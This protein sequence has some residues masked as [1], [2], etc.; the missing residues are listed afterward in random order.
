MPCVGR[1]PSDKNAKENEDINHPGE[2]V[3]YESSAGAG[4]LEKWEA[5]R[6]VKTGDESKA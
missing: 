3:T 2:N 5:G 4:V 1:K 6:V